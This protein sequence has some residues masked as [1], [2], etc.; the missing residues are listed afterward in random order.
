M[1]SNIESNYLKTE[2]YELIKTDESIFDFI[3][4]SSLDGLWYWDLENPENEWMNAKFWTVLGYNP[5]EM[6]HKSSSWQNIINQDDLKVAIDNFTKHCENSD[7]PYDQIV[8]YTHKNGSTIW[9]RCRGLAIRDVNGTPI[10]M[11]GAHQD[12]SEIKRTEQESIYAKEKA[13]ESEK[14]FRNMFEFHSAIML[15]VEPESGKIINANNSAVEFYGYDLLTLRS[16]SIQDINQLNQ[17]QI[18]KE[19]KR[20]LKKNCNVFIF[21][22]KLSNGEIR[23]VEVHSTPIHHEGKPILFSII[24][25]ITQRNKA[26]KELIKAKEKAEESD[27]LKTAFLQNMS[28]EIRTPLNAISGF[29]QFLLNPGFS[30]EKRKEFVSIIQ[31]SSNQL[32]SVVSDILSISFLE[33][34]QE[35]INNEIVNVNSLISELEMIFNQQLCL[36]KIELKVVKSLTDIESTIFI[37]RVKLTQIISNLINNADKFT[38]EGTIEI[39]YSLKNKELE[40]YVKDTGIG[41]KEDQQEKIFERFRQADMSI[42]KKYG[43]TGLGLAISK[44]Y[45][46]LLGGKIWVSSEIGKGSTFSFTIPYIPS[47][48]AVKDKALN[49]SGFKKRIKILIAEDEPNNYLFFETIL[50]DYDCEILHAEDGREAIELYK[51]NPDIDFILM[52]IKMAHIDGIQA[53]KIIKSINSKVPVIA[54]TAYGLESEVL[55]FKEFFDDY[56]VKPINIDDFR[57]KISKLIA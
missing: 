5:E 41:I 22:H 28:H 50:S 8:R 35:K 33:T 52:D 36:K 14:R 3:Q 44:G 56:L 21:P 31:N 30:E 4:E 13:I 46:E 25:D 51:S 12:I 49:N 37:D 54:Q 29:S 57:Q 19:C 16:M 39:G 17:E 1:D 48:E 43:G 20:A 24:H 55:D 7:H 2:L 47:E 11:L 53:T 34:K 6:P 23:T 38:E 40:F 45:T 32:I 42:S 9:I 18:K 27:N 15:L 10:R 26:E